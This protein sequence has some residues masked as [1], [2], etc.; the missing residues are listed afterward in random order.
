MIKIRELKCWP[1]Y[2]SNF[3]WCQ[4]Y[5][6]KTNKKWRLYNAIASLEWRSELTLDTTNQSPS[7][8]ISILES[9]L[10]PNKGKNFR[11]RDRGEEREEQPR[12]LNRRAV[13]TTSRGGADGAAESLCG[14]EDEIEGQ[15][16]Q[17]LEHLE[18]L[19]EHHCN[20]G[21]Y[22]NVEP[23]VSAEVVFFSAF[24]SFLLP[25]SINGRC[26]LRVR[27]HTWWGVTRTDP[28]LDQIR[29][30]EKQRDKSLSLS[31]SNR[32]RIYFWLNLMI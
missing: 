15:I 16:Q 32:E 4:Q 23:R 7:L 5:L 28:Q 3:T 20:V 30:L 17:A 31:P 26:R 21:E 22:E 19:H 6:N 18:S 9:K 12:K 13:G 24:F 25:A 14:D 10:R 29:L 8:P 2:E 1:F 11:G 27:F